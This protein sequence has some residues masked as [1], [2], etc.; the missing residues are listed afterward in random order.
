MKSNILKSMIRT[1]LG[2]FLLAAAAVFSSSI[3]PNEK[4]QHETE[5][6][7]AGSSEAASAFEI[8]GQC[9]PRN[10]GAGLAFIPIGGTE[11]P[12]SKLQVSISVANPLREVLA[13]WFINRS[14]FKINKTIF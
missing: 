7:N 11:V 5:S 4:V 12:K 9:A 2:V 10:L 14:P 3:V 6:V 8:G 1:I 13:V